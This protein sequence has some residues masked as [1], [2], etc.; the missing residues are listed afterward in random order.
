MPPSAAIVVPTRE[1]PA[2]LEVALRSIVPQAERAGAE[3]LVVDDGAHAATRAAAERCGA[4]YRSLGP[5]PRGLN[6]A[7]NAGVAAT[8]G[9]LVVFTDDD[10]EAPDGWLDA[11]LMGADRWPEDDVLGGPIHPWIEGGGPRSCGR[12]GPP[13]TFLDL[14]AED[15]EAELVWGANLAIRRRAFARLGGFDEALDGFGAGDEED[16]Q[17]RY[18]AAGGRVRYVAGAAVVHRRAGADARLPRLARAAYG[19]GR[20]ARRYDAFRRAAPAPRAEALLLARC[21]GHAARRRC[22]TGL[23]AAAHAAGR[24]REAARRG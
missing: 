6:S 22:A 2:Y 24:L 9:G 17:R 19:R 15:R 4:A 1:R 12:E 11:L 8:T 18:R 14:G 5:A 10:V 23:L 7:R 21:L 16:W 20:S 3:V 13:V